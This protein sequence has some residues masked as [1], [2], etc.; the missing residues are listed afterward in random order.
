[1]VFL[2]SAQ[3]KGRYRRGESAVIISGRGEMSEWRGGAPKK[4]MESLD[5]YEEFAMALCLMLVSLPFVIAY[6]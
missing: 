2:Y 3:V 1:M 5:L 6:K 4:I